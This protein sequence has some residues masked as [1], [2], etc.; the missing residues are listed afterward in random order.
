ML[1]GVELYDIGSVKLFKREVL[2]K[3]PVFYRSAFTEAERLLKA[4][5]LGYRIGHID[6]EHRARIDG[7]GRGA[8]LKN[9][10][11][12]VRDMIDFRINQWPSLNKQKR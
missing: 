4:H 11:N 9:I 8:S 2:T 1:F 6:V 12:A 7:K 3:T 10:I 5:T